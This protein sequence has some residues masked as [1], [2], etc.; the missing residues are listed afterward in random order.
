MT[1]WADHI[2][3][4]V[5]P[6]GVTLLPLRGYEESA[7]L[8]ADPEQPSIRVDLPCP[9]AELTPPSPG[10]V[11]TTVTNSDPVSSALP[12]SFSFSSLSGE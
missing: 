10:T 9:P 5:Q 3:S 8:C 7:L 2:E 1:E 6:E 12:F 4:L 11:P